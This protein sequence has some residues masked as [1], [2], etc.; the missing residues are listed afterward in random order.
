MVRSISISVITM[1]FVLSMIGSKNGGVFAGK[2]SQDQKM[3]LSPSLARIM[4]ALSEE[5]KEVAARSS[6]AYLQQSIS[7]DLSKRDVYASDMAQLYLDS[8]K[9]DWNLALTKLRETL[10]FRQKNNLDKL[11]LEP[12]RL[13]QNLSQ[14]LVYV[15]GYDRDGRA[16]WIG[17]PRETKNH[18][19]SATIESAVFTMEKAIAYSQNKGHEQVTAIPHYAGIDK[20]KDKQ[21]LSVARQVMDTLRRHYVGRVH[22]IYLVDAPWSLRTIWGMLKPFAG[23]ATRE[24]VVFVTGDSEKESVLGPILDPDQASEWMLPQHRKEMA[25]SHNFDLRAYLDETPFDKTFGEQD[26]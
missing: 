12:H 17:V 26:D 23:Q 8:K 22:R 1:A 15:R 19:G 10:I 3:P 25:S 20:M 5:E 4:A 21:P 18:E 11:R 7:G 14:R 13:H 24:K 6:Y 9:N 2:H 16:L